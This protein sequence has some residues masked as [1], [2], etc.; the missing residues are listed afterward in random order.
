M[1]KSITKKAKPTARKRPK[2]VL[3]KAWETRRAKLE[4]TQQAANQLRSQSLASL[5]PGTKTS[6]T[7]THRSDDNAALGLD[8]ARRA[9]IVQGRS[10]LKR[11]TDDAALCGIVAMYRLWDRSGAAPAH[12]PAMI[13]AIAMKAVVEHLESLGYTANG[14]RN[15]EEKQWRVV[16]R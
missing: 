1:K 6:E 12:A 2:S 16:T 3:R 5:S 10:D 13:S 4:A 15:D 11:E 8:I 14:K 9:G 7:A